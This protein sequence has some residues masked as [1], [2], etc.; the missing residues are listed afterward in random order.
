MLCPVG[1][2]CQEAGEAV[3]GKKAAECLA[4][5]IL[6]TQSW[7]AFRRRIQPSFHPAK[8]RQETARYAAGLIGLKEDPSSRRKKGSLLLSIPD[9]KIRWSLQLEIG[10]FFF[11]FLIYSKKWD[12]IQENCSP[13]LRREELLSFCFFSRALLGLCDYGR[14][15]LIQLGRVQ[16]LVSQSQKSCD[17]GKQV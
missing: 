5:L 10:V 8:L 15:I 1:N 14:H 6:C 13:K 4:V 11:L 3:A 12:E 16:S 7:A 9:F 2:L 17:R